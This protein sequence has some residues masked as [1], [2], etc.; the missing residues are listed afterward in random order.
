VAAASGPSLEKVSPRRGVVEGLFA[1]VIWGLFPL[2]FVLLEAV[3]AI[4][5]AANRVLWTFVLCLV[6]LTVLRRW[7]VLGALLRRPK[8]VFALV[9][10]GFA[11][12][13]NWWI[14]IWAVEQN[15][16]VQGALGYYINPLVTV[17]FG[18]VLLRERLS[19]GQV[20]A[21][22]IA[23]VAVV[24]LTI[25]YGRP[26]WIALSLACT[27]GLYGLA[28]KLVSATA[29]ESLTVETAAVLLPAT[30]LILAG[31]V[32]GT[33][34]LQTATTFEVVLLVASGALTAGPLL[35]F[36]RASRAVPLTVM[37]LMQYATPTIQFIVGVVIL[38]EPMPPSRFIGF[39]LVWL[40]LVVLT[41]DGLR[42]HRATLD[43]AVDPTY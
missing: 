12:A 14:Y 37:G 1:Y 16:V 24:V 6:M 8:A 15:E 23:A 21:L 13:A 22:A 34:A 41:V 4:E 26:P 17:L 39:A 33:S 36:G 29:I 43:P 38:N 32:N 5:V 25:D 7:P 11:L 42:R 18:V 27:F 19:R 40:A 2:Y 31:L 30:V 9:V 35:L 20:V 10:G 3:P 28:K